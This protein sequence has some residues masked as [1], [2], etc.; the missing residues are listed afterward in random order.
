MTLQDRLTAATHERDQMIQIQQRAI[1]A[2][3]EAGVAL[4]RL[5]G[6]IA[7]LKDLIAA[8]AA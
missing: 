2:A 8:E 6:Q 3:N 4:A 7:L 5:D 1:Q